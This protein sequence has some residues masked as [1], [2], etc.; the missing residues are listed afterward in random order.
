M[1]ALDG[2]TP[3]PHRN[4][5]GRRHG[6]ALRPTQR[7][8]L[9]DLLP[10]LAVPD[11]RLGPV[12]PAALLPDAS[13]IWLEIGFGGGE[14][15]AALA[16]AHPQ[17]GLLG[18]EPFINGVAMALNQIERAG[19]T[20][21]RL[22]AGDARDLIDALPAAS[23]A[24]VYLLYPDPWPKPRH[25]RRRFMNPENLATLARAM[26]PGAEL[27]LATDIQAYAD[28][29]RAAAAATPDFTLLPTDPSQPWDG[30]LPTRYERKALAAGREPHYLRFQRQGGTLALT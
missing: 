2:G 4:F 13:E 22:H 17:I 1:T 6:K 20:N 19:A 16:A 7:R 14:H 8:H 15:L 18:A 24:R 27:R 21:V 28:H 9:D 11:P 30:W 23:L 29:A 10:R 12:D 3:P 25:H 5:Y 26:R